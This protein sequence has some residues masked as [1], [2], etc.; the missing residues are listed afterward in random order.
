MLFSRF[1]RGALNPGKIRDFF[2]H[3]SAVVIFLFEVFTYLKSACLTDTDPCK[4]RKINMKLS[5]FM[6]TSL[7]PA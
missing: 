1:I 3:P 6:V 4:N 5:R 2:L 7:V